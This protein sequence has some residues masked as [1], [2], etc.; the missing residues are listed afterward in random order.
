M[1]TWQTT[2]RSSIVALVF[3]TPWLFCYVWWALCTGHPVFTQAAFLKFHETWGAVIGIALS[4]VIAVIAAAIPSQVEA[5]VIQLSERLQQPLESFS[6]IH[7]KALELLRW[8]DNQPGSVYGMT[9][10]TPVFG[11]ELSD[12]IRGEWDNTLR[13]RLV[14]V[15]NPRA[16]TELFCLNPYSPDGLDQSA[17]WMFC[18]ELE[19][20]GVLK[21][22]SAKNAG[23]LFVRSMD[24]I[25]AFAKTRVHEASFSM[26]AGPRPPVHFIFA[27]N[28]AGETQCILYFT[29]V[30]SSA[31]LIV[32]GFVSG[33]ERW[34]KLTDHVRG[35]LRKQSCDALDAFVRDRRSDE[36]VS[37]CREL[38]EYQVSHRRPYEAIVGGISVT[39]EP[40]VFPPDQGIG[41]ELLV[42]AIAQECEAIRQ[43]DPAAVLIGIDVGTGTGVLAL[44]LARHCDQVYASDISRVAVRNA[45]Q[46]ISKFV[47]PSEAPV[48]RI[49][50]REANLLSG[51][52]PFM[53]DTAA[54]LV[55]NYP[56][57]PSALAVFNTDGRDSA[58]IVVVQEFLEQAKPIVVGRSIV[59]M[60]FSSIAG[61]DNNPE[62]VATRFG[63]K[64]KVVTEKSA[65]GRTDRV[66]AFTRG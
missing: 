66:Y 30:E 44:A 64:T 24:A 62:K 59:L 11:I 3:A 34:I 26:W 1:T 32:N 41:V 36:Q 9:S 2:Y 23:D 29:G 49:S 7:A 55:F 42:A 38:L 53:P 63:Y 54:V 52:P 48:A 20:S 65:A 58:G 10:A 13:R 60:P 45:E 50:V 22:S 43:H 6:A 14:T 46:N 8:V 5:Q 33:D 17:L 51:L 31:G 21:D 39:V 28:S 15:L 16:E 47:S 61:E 25:E 40:D 35:H 56:F 18:V 12:Q 4:V 57:Y 19:R 27:R 37:R